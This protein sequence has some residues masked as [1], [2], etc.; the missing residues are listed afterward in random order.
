MFEEKF[1]LLEKIS[2]KQFRR[3]N[4]NNNLNIIF[5]IRLIN[6]KNIEKKP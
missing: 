6:Y 5:F 1:I 2:F 3:K 4:N